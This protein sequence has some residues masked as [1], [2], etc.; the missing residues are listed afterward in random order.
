[1]PRYIDADELKRRF[2]HISLIEWNKHATTSW[3][4]AFG[5]AADMID[6]MPTADVAEVKRGRWE[7]KERKEPLYDLMGVKTWGVAWQC[8]ECG[9]IHTRIEN[10]GRYFACPN[11]GAKMDEVEE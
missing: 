1:M 3:A 5:E 2:E 4:Y 7:Y 11:C 10:H 6:D 8:S 9:F